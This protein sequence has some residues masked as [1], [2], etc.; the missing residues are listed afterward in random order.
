ML[1]KKRGKKKSRGEGAVQGADLERKGT[2]CIGAWSWFFVSNL[3]IP[4]WRR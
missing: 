3:G 1:I 4:A 2:Y